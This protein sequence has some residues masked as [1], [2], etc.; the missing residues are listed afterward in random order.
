MEKSKKRLG[1]FKTLKVT[2]IHRSRI[3]TL[4]S[5][6]MRAF[7]GRQFC[8][9]IM[10]HPGAAVIVPVLSDGRFV[11][12]KQFRTAVK[13]AIYEF[14]AGTLEAGEAPLECAKRELIEETGFF[15]KKWHK[16]GSFYPAPGVSTEQ[17]HL[18][19]AGGLSPKNGL[20]DTDEFLEP[21]IMSFNRLQKMIQNGTIMDAKTIIGFF[22]YCQKA[23]RGYLRKSAR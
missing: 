18:Y 3:F 1:T 2:D 16:L 12:V 20:S 23:G 13:K 17:M 21:K 8:H 15:A 6:L 4:R 22:Y 19:L 11:L 10:F 7:N 5:V 14:P 9:D